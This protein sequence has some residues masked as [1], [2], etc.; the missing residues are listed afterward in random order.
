M[1]W[2]HIR[3]FHEIAACGSFVGAASHLGLTQPS[4]SRHMF[5]LQKELGFKLFERNGRNIRLTEEGE[6]FLEKSGPLLTLLKDLS[7]IKNKNTK[8][9]GEFVIS[10]G[11]TVAACILPKLLSRLRYQNPDLSFRVIEGDASEI[12]SS[13]LRGEADLGIIT[14][15]LEHKSLSHKFF[16]TDE[17]CVVAH[18]NNRLTKQ[19]RVSFQELS[20]ESFVMFHPASAIRQTVEKKFHKYRWKPRII[21]ELQG[22]DS[23]R[24]CIE[25]QLGLGFL[26]TLTLSNQ[27][28]KINIPELTME[29]EFY[30]CSRKDR[31]TVHMLI[32]MMEK[33]YQT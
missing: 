2:Q 23:V 17:I 4:L 18:K 5:L 27:L 26:S 22:V 24:S 20:Q 31:E 32:A 3:S 10:T 6:I 13:L 19:R 8:L 16:F 9:S 15:K 25:E 12:K 14:G 29:R 21:M 11:G 7:S 28:R 1:N 33:A 30:F